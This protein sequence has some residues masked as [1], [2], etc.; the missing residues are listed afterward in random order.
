MSIYRKPRGN[1]EL[2]RKNKKPCELQERSADSQIKISEAV[3]R[4]S[5]PQLE[6][7]KGRSTDPRDIEIW[8]NEGG[9]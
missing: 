8:L 5:P 6:E 3:P 4:V 1:S 7:T 9:A 2:A